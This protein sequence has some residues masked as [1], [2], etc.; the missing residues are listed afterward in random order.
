MF[1]FLIL[2]LVILHLVSGGD[3]SEQDKAV[4]AEGEDTTEFPT[5][6]PVEMMKVRNNDE[7]LDTI[8]VCIAVL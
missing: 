8:C 7:G 1:P 4:T 2:H 3:L 6:A 5:E